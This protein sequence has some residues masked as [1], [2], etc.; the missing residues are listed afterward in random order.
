[1]ESTN[2]MT[3]FRRFTNGLHQIRSDF[4]EQLDEMLAFSEIMAMKQ[5]AVEL[6]ENGFFYVTASGPIEEIIP[7]MYKQI[8]KLERI[9]K[10]KDST[11]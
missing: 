2:R 10:Q 3:P 1:M 5:N 4:N 9:K 7:I 6:D 8:E 11:L